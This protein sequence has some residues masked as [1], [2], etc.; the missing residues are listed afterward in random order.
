MTCSRLTVFSLAVLWLSY[1]A[2]IAVC[3]E[4]PPVPT[5]ANEPAV[6]ESLSNLAQRIVVESLPR[7]FED[8]KHWGKTTKIIDG[9]RFKDDGDGLKLRKHTAEVKD[10]VWKQYKAELIDPEHQLQIR[11]ANIR[12]TDAGHSAFQ[13]FLSARLRGEAQIEQWKDG[14]KLFNANAQADSQIEARLDCEIAWDWKA[15]GILG[16]FTIEPKVTG[17]QIELVEFDLKKVS[18][19]EGW[20]ARELGENFKGV[21][22]KKLHDEEPKLVD[23]LN[24]AIQKRQDRLRFSPDDVVAG[25]LSKLES[26]FNIEKDNSRK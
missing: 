8:K 17:A 22:A 5:P 13:V 6:N 14:I 24:K 26:L 4:T 23:K 15:S 19:I 20:A 18:K 10:G 1:G 16:R 9:L 11:V 2:A 3:A 21:I 7:Q 25:G 12:Q